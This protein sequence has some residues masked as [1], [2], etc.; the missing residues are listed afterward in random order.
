MANVLLHDTFYLQ[1][2]CHT[3]MQRPLLCL[4][5]SPCYFR[6]QLYPQKL[7]SW[8]LLQ[9]LTYSTSSRSEG[10][11]PQ[12]Q[13]CSDLPG[14]CYTLCSSVVLTLIA[15]TGS[16]RQLGVALP[17]TSYLHCPSY[18]RP[19]TRAQKRG[20]PGAR[21][22]L[23]A[24]S[25]SVSSVPWPGQRQDS[26]RSLQLPATDTLGWQR[27]SAHCESYHTA[28]HGAGSA[29]NQYQATDWS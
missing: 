9:H 4:S 8:S 27:R 5:P 21:R 3:L 12:S 2:T 29:S 16:C 25:R 15:S 6:I 28:G 22:R 18:R 17:I 20:R 14:A 10:A 26:P 11:S 13:M 23:A 7:S 1:K 19:S 24:R